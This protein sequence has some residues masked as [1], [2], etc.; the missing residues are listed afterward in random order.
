MAFDTPGSK[1][2]RELS[3]TVS[4]DLK[5]HNVTVLLHSVGNSLIAKGP[6]ILDI[7]FIRITWKKENITNKFANLLGTYKNTENETFIEV[8]FDINGTNHL[9]ASIGYTKKKFTYGYTYSPK[10]YLDVN[11][12]RVMAVS[13][14]STSY[15]L[16][17]FVVVIYFENW[18]L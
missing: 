15:V 8:G 6:L 9:D 4:F 2:K 1:M 3:A 5:H 18:I 13:G 16:I 17:I 14:I 11:S 12:E 7:L 10:F